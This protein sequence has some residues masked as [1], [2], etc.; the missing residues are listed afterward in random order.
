MLQWA[1]TQPPEVRNDGRGVVFRR[2]DPQGKGE[3]KLGLQKIDNTWYVL[4]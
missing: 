2:P 1:L 4:L 3:Q